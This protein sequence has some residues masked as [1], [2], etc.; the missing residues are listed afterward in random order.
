MKMFEDLENVEVTIGM[1]LIILAMLWIAPSQMGVQVWSLPMGILISIVS[2]PLSY[3]IIN[4]VAN[5]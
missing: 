2:L 4:G 1:W 5:R 3:L